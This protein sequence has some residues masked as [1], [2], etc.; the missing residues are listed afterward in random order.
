MSP[1]WT[2]ASSTTQ[3]VRPGIRSA[4]AIESLRV[5]RVEQVSTRRWNNE[6][7]LTS[8]DDVNGEWLRW[9]KSAHELGSS[10]E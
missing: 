8:P 10:A 2:R 6:L 5:R 1:S 7:L 3:V 4:K 9:L